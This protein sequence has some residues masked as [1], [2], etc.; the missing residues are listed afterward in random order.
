MAKLN[1]DLKR[2]KECIFSVNESVKSHEYLI[3]YYEIDENIIEKAD[4]WKFS[5]GR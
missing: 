1:Y 4:C 2:L 5:F 3:N